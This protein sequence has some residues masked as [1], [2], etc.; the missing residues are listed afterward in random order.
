MV[1]RNAGGGTIRAARGS[2]WRPS[3]SCVPLGRPRAGA[4]LSRNPEGGK[5]WLLPSLWLRAGP[6]T[7]SGQERPATL[8]HA[9][10]AAPTLELACL[11]SS[12]DSVELFPCRTEHT[13]GPKAGSVGAFGDGGR[14]KGLIATFTKGFAKDPGEPVHE[15]Q[16]GVGNTHFPRSPR[17]PARNLHRWVSRNALTARARRDRNASRG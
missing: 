13:V 8:D 7:A 1:S 5:P 16:W 4:E 15:H 10:G 6:G 17:S 12:C 11:A 14:L 2:R 9:S 3:G